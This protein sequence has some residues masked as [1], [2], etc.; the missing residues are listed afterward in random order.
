MLP[1]T[2]CASHILRP[3]GQPHNVVLQILLAWGVIGGLACLALALWV[4]PR[5]IRARS[6]EAAPFQCA[7]L[8]LAA[9]SMYDGTL[10][11]AHSTALFMLCCAAAVA[12]DLPRSG[13]DERGG[14]GR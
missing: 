1:C 4:A 6:A 10:Y 14:S 11:Y 12:A 3:F 5:F 9:Y 7:A 2:I 13:G 8:S